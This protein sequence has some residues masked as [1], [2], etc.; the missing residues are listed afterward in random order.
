MEDAIKCYVCKIF[1]VYYYKEFVTFF[2][3]MKIYHAE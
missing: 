2:Q 1:R 3:I